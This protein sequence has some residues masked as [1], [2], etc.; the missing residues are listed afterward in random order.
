MKRPT[1]PDL[2]VASGVSVST[3]NRVLNQAD[4][5]RQPTRERVLAAAEEI[6]FYGLGTVEH[7]V[8][9]GR[10]TH[11][12][13][14]LLQPG[15]RTFYRNLGNAMSEAARTCTHAQV[16]LELEFLEDLSPE[17]IADHIQSLG[18]RCE[19][20]AVVAPQHPLIADAI[21]SVLERGVPVAGLIGLLSAQGDVSFVGLDYWKVGAPPLGHSTR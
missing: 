19:A 6:G 13:G 8:R 17:R 21:D 12:L 11:R 5:V 7:A 20:I 16:D 18:E 14:V 9:I 3:V 15:D 10:P 1:I 4:S 2:A